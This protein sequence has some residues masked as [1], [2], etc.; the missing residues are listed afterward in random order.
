M[1]NFS[2]AI[3]GVLLIPMTDGESIFIASF[4]KLYCQR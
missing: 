3:I 2:F 1:F 4:Q